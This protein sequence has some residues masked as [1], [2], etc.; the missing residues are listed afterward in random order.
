MQDFG[1]LESAAPGEGQSGGIEEL[2]EDAKQRF[3]AA[4]KA[5]KA[6]QQ[7]ERR[8]KRRDQKIARA[9]IR[10]LNDDRYTHL[11]ILISRL[12]G[13]D[14]P[15]IFLL[16]ILSLIDDEAAALVEDFLGDGSTAILA[17]KAATPIVE[18]S[19]LSASSNATLSEWMGRVQG[20]LQREHAAILASLM[21]DDRNIDGSILQLTTFVLQAFFESAHGGKK[22]VPFEKLQPLTASILT[23]LFQPYIAAAQQRR[24]ITAMVQGDDEEANEKS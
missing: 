10:F 13:R 17:E 8:S 3:A 9:I 15:S 4:A 14:C 7:E 2:S 1:G 18:H 21:L 5:G 24:K 19:A 22:K 12:V 16:A 11:F 23:T 6:L 20:V